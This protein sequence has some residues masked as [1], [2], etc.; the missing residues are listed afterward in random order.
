MPV[1]TEQPDL[2]DLLEAHRPDVAENVKATYGLDATGRVRIVE[3]VYASCRF[4]LPPDVDLSE[5][6]DL[7]NYED[8]CM[9]RLLGGLVKDQLSTRTG[10]RDLW[11]LY[12]L[13]SVERGKNATIIVIGLEA[14]L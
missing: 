2:L 5:M 14:G 7:L 13:V 12:R 1:T 11:K 4:E 8:R 3:G 6:H 10:W 9:E